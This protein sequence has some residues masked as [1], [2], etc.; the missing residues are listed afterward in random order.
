MTSL[1]SNNKN[2]NIST[3]PLILHTRPDF[4]G[5]LLNFRQFLKLEAPSRL[6]SEVF[7]LSELES[8]SNRKN[9][10]VQKHVDKNRFL[11]NFRSHNKRPK[12]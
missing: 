9:F 5:T 7:E 8:V 11:K 6:G 10:S 2:K 4:N 12:V 1:F 3:G